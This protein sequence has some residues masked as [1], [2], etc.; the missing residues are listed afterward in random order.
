MTTFCFL[1]KYW[2]HRDP[3]Q[4]RRCRQDFPVK[5]S[6]GAMPRNRENREVD[7]IVMKLVAKLRLRSYPQ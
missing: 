1:C 5:W 2:P 6:D 7:E 3:S 4:S